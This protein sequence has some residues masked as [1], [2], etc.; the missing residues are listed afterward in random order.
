M[1]TLHVV[2]LR[3]DIISYDDVNVYKQSV[4]QKHTP[5]VPQSHPD[6]VTQWSGDNIDHNIN[7][8]DR[9]GTF[10]EMGQISMSTPCHRLEG[11]HFNEVSVP[12]LRRVTFPSLV[13]NREIQIL[14][15][16]YPD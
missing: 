12:Q 1:G 15:Y 10:H 16:N 8:I 7:T 2:T 5:D 11:V 3:F 9:S 13:R 14:P 4:M 6:S